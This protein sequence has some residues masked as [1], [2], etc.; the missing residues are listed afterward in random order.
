MLSFG[1]FIKSHRLKLGLTLREFC[2]TYGHDPSNWSKLERG[3]IPPPADEKTLRVWAEQ[4]GITEYSSDWYT[5]I[6]L[7][8]I[9]KGIIPFDLK[10]N[11]S[12]LEKLP[13]FY[14]TLRGQ[15]PTENEM[16]KIAELLRE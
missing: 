11:Q 12:A 9:E 6:D 10:K 2:K 1:D 7:A 15:K 5:M 16:K 13:L 4:L 8:A 3:V 14:R